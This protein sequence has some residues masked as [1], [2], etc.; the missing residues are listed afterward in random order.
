[1][2]KIFQAAI[3]S[4]LLLALVF[5]AAAQVPATAQTEAAW[6][7]YT[8]D[9]E[10][11]SVALPEMPVLDHSGRYVNGF[12]DR[13]GTARSYGA[14]RDDVVYLIRAF[15]K[16]RAGEDLDYFA[17]DY[18]RTF[19][20]AREI[21]EFKAQ[22]EL[23]RGKFPGRQ[24]A[25]VNNVSSSSLPASSL[26]VFLTKRHAYVLRAVGGDDDHP[27]VRRFINSFTLSDKPAGRQVL[28]ESL[29]MPSLAPVAAA[30]PWSPDKKRPPASDPQ[31]GGSA[32]QASGV[33]P[34]RGEKPGV[35]TGMGVGMGRGE[36][37]SGV[38][39]PVSGE[40][41]YTRTFRSSEVSRKAQIIHKPEPR[42]TEEA[43]KNEVT[44]TVRL[45][46]VVTADGKVSNIVPLSRL[47]DGLIVTATIAAK[48]IK[49]IP[50]VKDGR[51]VSQ[52]VTIEYNFHIY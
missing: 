22:R 25:I 49:F 35:G 41:D 46:L 20:L 15:D 3:L 51:K 19:P 13:D 50:A 30:A 6:E 43:R 7:T 27:G 9:G 39:K 2:R 29:S 40:V 21:P 10:E 45:R 28:D 1:M 37:G 5:N 24:Y 4:L 47:P 36:G 38:S 44:G 48:H 33:A 26:Y 18:L 31:T 11:F 17:G 14:Y 8:F 52:Y 12:P 23:S 42:Y 34:P 16:P 32:P